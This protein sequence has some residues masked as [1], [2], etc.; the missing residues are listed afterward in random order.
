MSTTPTPPTLSAPYTCRNG[1]RYI[2]R[3]NPDAMRQRLADLDAKIAATR[4]AAPTHTGDMTL[5]DM[6]EADAIRN[7]LAD[8]ASRRLPDWGSD[9]H[10]SRCGI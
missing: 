4:A 3:G 10:A 8:Y 7:A 2:A 9:Y 5:D 6:A 1:R